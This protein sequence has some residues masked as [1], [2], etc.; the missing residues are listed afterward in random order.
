MQVLDDLDEIHF[1]MKKARQ[2]MR[3]MAKS[4]ATD[5]CITVLFV[6]VALGIVA[7]VVLRVLKSKGVI[8]SAAEGW[9]GWECFWVFMFL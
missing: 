9:M 4:L 1:T 2:I 7:V 3:D 8:V 5:T 6:L